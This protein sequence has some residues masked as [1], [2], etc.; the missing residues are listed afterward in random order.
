[1]KLFYYI[2]DNIG[3]GI[4]PLVFSHFIKAPLTYGNVHWGSTQARNELDYCIYGIGSILG[5][6]PSSRSVDI[7]CGSGFIKSDMVPLPVHKIISVRGPLTRKKYLDAGM[8]CPEQ[9][10]DLALLFRYIIPP[11]LTF[12]KKYKV[13]L[14]PHFVDKTLPIVQQAR[15]K[16]WK[17]IDICQAETPRKFIEE[18]HECELI[19]SS[20]LHGIILADSYGIPAYHTNLSNNVIG[21]EFKFCDYYS[22]VERDYFHVSIDEL[23]KCVPYTVKFNF[24]AYYAYIKISLSALSRSVVTYTGYEML[25]EFYAK[26]FIEE[27][28]HGRYSNLSIDHILGTTTIN[29][30]IYGLIFPSSMIS[31]ISGLSKDKRYEYYF[32]GLITDSRKWVHNF[33]SS[34]SLIQNSTYGRDFSKKYSYDMDYYT[35]MSLSKFVICPVGGCPWS[36]R[37]FEAIMC[38]AIPIMEK[39]TIDKYCKDY[40]YFEVG[41]TYIYSHEVAL[42]NYT[43]FLEKNGSPLKIA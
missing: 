39:N 27:T 4:N 9:Y 43:I 34:S 21:G 11:P 12:S 6:I 15:E 8:E 16:G 32:K 20:S 18:I 13:G 17:I 31:M 19:L 25:Q 7:V 3:D 2:S 24:D 40:T 35:N 41:D 36:Y 23:N 5:M 38:F 33:Q 29:T 28:M 37:F 22:S 42:K 10:G 14:I 30:Q 26:K 1:M